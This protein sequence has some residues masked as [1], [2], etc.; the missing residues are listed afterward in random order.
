MLEPA[1]TFPLIA[2]WFGENYPG[3]GKTQRFS[4]YD[5]W[6]GLRLASQRDLHEERRIGMTLVD[7]AGRTW[8]IRRIWSTGL[9][10]SAWKRTLFRLFG[11]RD[12]LLH[13]VACEFDD[14]G[15][16]PFA[17]V[18]ARVCASIEQNPD[19]WIDDEAVAGEGGVEPLDVES[20]I[21]AVKGAVYRARTIEE[22]YDR[23]VE[24]DA[25]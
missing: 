3:Q 22:I 13:D 8:I 24:V 10:T 11:R 6:D 2:F 21:S 12:R 18:Q 7:T 5:D 17:E 19:D 16:T 15:F 1:A 4:F 25:R 23:L 20:V 14:R 9:R